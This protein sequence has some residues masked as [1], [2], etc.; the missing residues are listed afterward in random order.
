MQQS[1]YKPEELILLL[2]CLW[3]YKQSSDRIQRETLSLKY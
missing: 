3:N 2:L 1:E